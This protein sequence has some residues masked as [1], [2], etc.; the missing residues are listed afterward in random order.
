MV[1][2]SFQFLFINVFLLQD[3]RIQLNANNN[4]EATSYINASPIHITVKETHQLA[5]IVAQ[6]PLRHTVNTFWQMVWESD[7]TVIAML[8]KLKVLI[9]I[10]FSLIFIFFLN[11]FAIFLIVKKEKKILIRSFDLVPISVSLAS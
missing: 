7:V 4:F 11:S 1:V 2:S 5:F 9:Y 3:N 8:S 10:L 6:S